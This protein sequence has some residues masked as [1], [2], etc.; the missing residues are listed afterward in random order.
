MKRL[1]LILALSLVTLPAFAQEDAEAAV[2]KLRE[3]LRNTMLQLRDAQ[4][5]IATLQATKNL[6]DSKIAEL[7][8]QNT[9]LTKQIA[10]DK[11]AADKEIADLTAENAAQDTRNAKQVE[12]LGKWKKSYDQLLEQAKAVVVKRDELAA[13]KILLDRKVADQQAK[14]QAMAA[15]GL[16]ILKRYEKFGLGDALT[17]R[18][19]FVGTTRVKFE[20]LVQDYSDKIADQ[21]VK[22]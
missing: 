17:A 12:A 20:N 11:T 2:A 14:N 18:E 9:K 7:T 3:G 16:E 8:A 4:G 1:I 15:L 10:A 13:Q 19:P 21:R 22:P 6:D 5:Q